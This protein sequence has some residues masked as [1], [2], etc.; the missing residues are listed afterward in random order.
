MKLIFEDKKAQALRVLKE[1]MRLENESELYYAIYPYLERAIDEFVMV[2]GGKRCKCGEPLPKKN[3]SGKCR[4]C[5]KEFY[6][7]KGENILRRN[8][9]SKVFY[10]NRKIKAYE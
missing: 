7:R 8:E 4:S 9:N 10:R 2:D 1:K 3:S 6:W 5:Y